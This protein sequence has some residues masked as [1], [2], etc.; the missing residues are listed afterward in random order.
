MSTTVKYCV[1]CVLPAE[2][3]E[4]A[5]ALAGNLNDNNLILPENPE[6][7]D[8]AMALDVRKLWEP[9][10]TLRVRFLDGDPIVQKKV[11]AVAH[12]WSEFANIEFSFGDDPE[13][14]IRIS[15]LD[16]GSWSYIGIDALLIPKNQATMNY[17]WLT[18]DTSDEEYHRVV[19][20]EFGHAL[21]CI[22]EHQNPGQGGIPW[23]EEAVIDAYSGSPNYWSTEQVRVNILNK[24]NKDQ[25]QYTDFD[26][27]SIM[28]YPVPQ[29]HTIGDFE[30]PWQNCQLSDADKR[31]I[32]EMYPL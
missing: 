10:R 4:L 32:G 27:A 28:L 13:A 26:R 5:K 30:V 8:D 22:H 2:K 21:G 25:T 20:H 16:S 24:Y 12:E 3:E 17:G 29:E 18:P 14:E 23:N 31:F 19:L 6:D 1:N 11:E 15:F 7:L 9:G